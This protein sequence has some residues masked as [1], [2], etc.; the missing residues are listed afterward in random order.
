M[1]VL[2]RLACQ[3]PV[4]FLG[5]MGAWPCF[6]RTRRSV[7]T[8]RY[9]QGI[10]VD[11]RHCPSPN[12]DLNPSYQCRNINL[13]SIDY[14]FRPR[15]RCRLTPG[16]RTCPGKPWDS[17]GRDSHPAFRYSCPHNHWHALHGRFRAP[18]RRCMPRSPTVV[19]E[20]RPANSVRRL[21]PDH[22]RRGVSRVVSCYALF[23]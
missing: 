1:S 7:R 15:L 2:V 16:G 9:V 8:F 11:P 4:F 13:P 12:T 18:L 20:G 22:F 3:Y 10:T 23:K 6:G 14:A 19:L 5:S 17:G 21:T